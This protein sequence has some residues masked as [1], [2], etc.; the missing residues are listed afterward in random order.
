MYRYHL[1]RFPVEDDYGD[2]SVRADM[3]EYSRTPG[4]QLCRGHFASSFSIIFKF[5]AEE[6]HRFT[7]LNISNETDGEEKFSVVVDMN[8]NRII[9]AFSD[10]RIS[11]L[12]LPLG[13]NV[14]LQTGRWHRLGIAVD[15][16]YISVYGDCVNVQKYTIN[17]GCTVP[18]DESIEVGVL[19]SPVNVTLR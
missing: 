16:S 9:L 10:C 4:E 17:S 11:S 15:P 14:T 5:R 8:S 2:L 18:C 3:N 1:S 12:E 7:L 6:L 13:K 19:E